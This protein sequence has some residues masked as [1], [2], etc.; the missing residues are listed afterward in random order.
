[1]A[2]LAY[3]TRRTLGKG[4]RCI[5]NGDV[6]LDESVYEKKLSLFAGGKRQRDT[7]VNGAKVTRI[8]CE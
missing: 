6:W 8:L 3:W 2:I 4:V 5:F 7:G 1:M